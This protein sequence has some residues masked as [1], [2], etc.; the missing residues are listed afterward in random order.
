M[1]LFYFF[2]RCGGE[3]GDEMWYNAGVKKTVTINLDIERLPEGYFLATSHDVDGLVVQAKTIEE[4]VEIAEDAVPYLL[5]KQKSSSLPK[6]I[7]SYPIAIS[8]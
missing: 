5:K 6:R 1:G 8:I 7:I 4:V 3:G 2:E